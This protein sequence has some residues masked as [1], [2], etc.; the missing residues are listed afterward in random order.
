MPYIGGTPEVQRFIKKYK[1]SGYL[2]DPYSKEWLAS[3]DARRNADHFFYCEIDADQYSEYE[4]KFGSE[5][6]NHL[7]ILRIDESNPELIKD[8]KAI[9]QPF[10]S[11]F[12]ERDSL[13]GYDKHRPDFILINL[14]IRKIL[15]IGLGRKNRLFDYDLDE[16]LGDVPSSVNFSHFTSSS[17]PVN[18]YYKEFVSL[19]HSL[20]IVSLIQALRDLGSGLFENASTPGN[21]DEWPDEPNE[22]GMY[23]VDDGEYTA[24]EFEAIKDD[25]YQAD[26]LMHDGITSI[27]LLFPEIEIGDLNTG[28]Y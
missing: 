13:S 15:C 24:E 12:E 21:P 17:N 14:N 6:W 20:I 18:S 2:I 25:Y 7:L 23:L 3:L 8:L 26:E 4:A 5:F 28:D 9:Y 27:N 11:I 1:A 10:K 22:D 16:Y 19:D